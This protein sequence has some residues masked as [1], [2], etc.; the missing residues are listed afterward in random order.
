MILLIT[1]LMAVVGAFLTANVSTFYI[2]TFY[3]QVEGVFGEDQR[4]FVSDLRSV[5]AESNGAD[6]INE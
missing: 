6:L 2:G 5:A 3:E 4:D 1:S